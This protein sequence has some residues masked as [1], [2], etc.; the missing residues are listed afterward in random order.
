VTKKEDA[1]KGMKQMGLDEWLVNI[2]LELFRIFR[3]GYGSQITTAVEQITRRKPAS[4]AQFAKDHAEFFQISRKKK[5]RRYAYP[6]HRGP[7]RA[8]LHTDS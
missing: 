7:D 8:L 3:V 5:K 2:V 4:F 6:I 1:R